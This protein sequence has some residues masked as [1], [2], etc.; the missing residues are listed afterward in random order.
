[1][2]SS[3]SQQ[4]RTPHFLTALRSDL[5]FENFGPN[6]AANGALVNREDPTTQPVPSVKQ[7][8]AAATYVQVG[9]I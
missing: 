6:Q 3:F 9:L 8:R 5:H 1:M 7:S 2:R 4:A